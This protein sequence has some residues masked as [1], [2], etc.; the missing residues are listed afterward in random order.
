[1]I[2]RILNLQTKNINSAALILAGAFLASA[3]LGFI[4]DRLLAGSF[5]AGDELDIYYTAFK[6]PDLLTMMLMTGAISAAIIPIFTEHLIKSKE[7]AWEYFSNLINLFLVI[8]IISALILFIFAP[9]LISLIAPGFSEEKRDLTVLLT[10]IMFL[11][12]IILGISNIISAI[13]RVFKRFL[14]TALAP[15]MYN[16]G[17]ICGIVF[18][19]PVFGLSGLAWGVAFGAVLHFLIQLPVLFKTGFKY[20]R[21]FDFR[22]PNFKK[23]IKLTLP[24][25][26]GLAASQINILVI[27][28]IAS[29]LSAGSIAIFNLAENLSR[30]L[31]TLVAI[32]FSTAAFPSLS[33]A[34]AKSQ[35]E[36]F[37]QIFY[38]VFRKILL[39]SLG[40]SALLFVFRNLMVDIILKAGKFSLIDAQ[41]TSACLAMFCIGIF[42]Q[43]LILLV[44]KT[45]YA[46]QN[47]KVPALTSVFAA[48][49]N[50]FLC[51][52]FVHLFS[53]SNS[54]RGFWV[55][56]LNL[57]TLSNIEVLGLPLALSFAAIFQ[58]S[59]LLV[60]LFKTK[61]VRKS[62]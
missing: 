59:L 47:T 28:I 42:A 26:L 30:P 61:Y 18:F 62:S 12:P 4:R 31:L 37:N 25:S 60:F 3:V 55:Q 39:L 41:L 6:I 35:K 1:M 16:L 11:S 20:R 24:R 38:S 36:K 40:L 56:G 51:L 49:I 53:F 14:I 2:E 7:E 19:V 21:I 10:R 8:L 44:A 22:K 29:T 54:F 50:V 57:Q 45:F 9:Q 23:T 17:I 5:G 52:Y 27:T 34:F 32:S 43:S 13:L 58:L 46:L 48:V 15:L 33:L